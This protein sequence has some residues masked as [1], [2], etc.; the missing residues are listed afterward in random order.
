[1]HINYQYVLKRAT[2]DF[3]SNG[4]VILDYGCG[5]GEVVEEGR[6]MGLDIYGV[7]VFYEGSSPEYKTRIENS[8]LL[9]HVIRTIDQG[10][11]PFEN[12][13]FNSVI[14]NMVFE[15]VEN[16]EGALKEIHRV[17]K[18]GGLFLCLFPA[19]DVI[20]ENHCGIPFLH[21]FGKRSRV[22]FLYALTMRRMGFGFFKGDKSPS[23]WAHDFL[24]WLDKFTYY[25]DREIILST[26]KRHFEISL[27]EH[28][29]ISFRLHSQDRQMLSRIFNMPFVQSLGCELFRR[30]GTLVILA[31]KEPAPSG[32]DT[33]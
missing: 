28:D 11:I 19:K 27:I 24:E 20:R 4:A 9:G 21:W 25:R 8:G 14:S 29:Y 6:K 22:R 3:D 26:F 12:N 13:Y 16:M 15:H 30:L 7:D 18:P 32:V 31:R 1:M 17:L 2:K 23:Q 33:N 5:A 10:T